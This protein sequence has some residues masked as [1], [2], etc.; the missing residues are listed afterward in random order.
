MNKLNSGSTRRLGNTQDRDDDVK[1]MVQK[2]E[3]YV[4]RLVEEKDTIDGERAPN[5]IKL[6]DQEIQKTHET[7]RLS[8]DTKFVDIVKEKPV[9]VSVKV[10]VPTKEFPKI[11]FVGKLMGPK[12]ST[13]KRLQ[14]ETMCKMAVQGK[15]CIK[16]KKKEEDLRQSNDPKYAHLNEPLHIDI[17]AL[18]PPA[19]AHA[20]I[21]FAL[22]EVRKYLSPDAG[23]LNMGPEHLEM[24]FLSGMEERRPPP[25][26]RPARPPPPMMRPQPPQMPPMRAPPVSRPILP[27]PMQVRPIPPAA[28]GVS[29]KTKVFS[30]L[31]RARV[32]ME[33]QNYGYGASGPSKPTRGDFDYEGPSASVGRYAADDQYASHEMDDVYGQSQKYGSYDY[34]EEPSAHSSRDYYEQPEYPAT[35]PMKFATDETTKRPWK[36]YKTTTTAPPSVRYRAAPYSRP[37]V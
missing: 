24:E 14:E 4:Q 28:R 18:A 29:T 16:D 30:I 5:V 3:E 19:E 22:A 2:V 7:G 8:S 17:V 31:D 37:T 15:G 25:P 20:R 34:E 26:P 33:N 35:R 12:G 10:M 36:S 13:M 6:I 1:K 9:R 27:P 23:E 21:A 32:A 11:N